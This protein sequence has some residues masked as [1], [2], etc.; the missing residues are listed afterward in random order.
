MRD[1]NAVEW[2]VVVG[3]ALLGAAQCYDIVAVKA[4]QVAKWVWG[5][6]R[7]SE[8]SSAKPAE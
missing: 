2:L 1:L 4:P 7:P 3:A 8:E 5:K 6:V